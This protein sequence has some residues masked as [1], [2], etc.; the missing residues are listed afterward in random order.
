MTL[1]NIVLGIEGVKV[2]EGF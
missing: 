1:P 2:G